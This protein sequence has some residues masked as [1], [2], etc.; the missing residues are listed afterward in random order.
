VVD[1]DAAGGDQVTP[2][3]E[4][5]LD[6]IECRGKGLPGEKTHRAAAARDLP[7]DLYAA[8]GDE[9]A[10]VA[11]LPALLAA[12]RPG[13]A[14]VQEPDGKALRERLRDVYGVKVPSTGNRWP[15]DPAAVRAALAARATADL[16][17]E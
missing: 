4:R 3:I 5:A 8:L 17:D 1:K 16:D 9:P 7:E 2:I 10:P 11:D 15:V 14:A 12:H 6:A 13:V